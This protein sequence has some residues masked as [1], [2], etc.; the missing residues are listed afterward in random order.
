MVAMM[1]AA[2]AASVAVFATW[3]QDVW[4]R[5]A[6]NLADRGQ[7]DAVAR[8][9]L[10]FGRRVL[11]ETFKKNPTSITLSD[12]WHRG[13]PPVPVENGTVSGVIDDAQG[14]YNLNNLVDP[15]RIPQFKRL[16]EL[17][18][19]SPDL[20]N[21]V[22]DWID[23][24]AQVTFPGGAEDIDYLGLTEPY[25][26]ANREM[27]DVDELMRVKGFDGKAVD[28]LRPFVTALPGGRPT[29]VNVNTAPKEVLSAVLDIDDAAAKNLVDKRDVKPFS[30]Q[31]DF[32]SRAK[33]DFDPS[34]MT[35]TVPQ[36]GQDYSVQSNFFIVNVRASFGRTQSALNALVSIQALNWPL[37]V[38]TQRQVD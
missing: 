24:D 5:Q 4:V 8:A 21:A 33:P 27:I 25:R 36:F 14:L 23:A 15:A 37:V 30:D 31:A 9:G 7:A 22:T 18:S 10:D 3:R 17:L 19:L 11:L 26:A 2:L 32:L 38:W 12:D 6:E 1:I 34:K 13:L 29:A 35:G 20:A 16:L 28:A